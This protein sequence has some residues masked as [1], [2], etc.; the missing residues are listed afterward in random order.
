MSN[1]DNNAS[2]YQLTGDPAIGLT[3]VSLDISEKI[4]ILRSSSKKA[5]MFKVLNCTHEL[6]SEYNNLVFPHIVTRRVAKT[7]KRVKFE[8]VQYR[9][10]LLFSTC[11]TLVQY[12]Y[13]YFRDLEGGNIS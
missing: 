13:L 8:K 10:T 3:M 6:Y 7:C 11:T 2:S 1:F 4:N 12:I 5:A 9:L